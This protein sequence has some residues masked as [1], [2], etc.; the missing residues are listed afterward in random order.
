MFVSGGTTKES[1][2]LFHK[3]EGL[4]EFDFECKFCN[5]LPKDICS[6]FEVV[7]NFRIFNLLL[8]IYNNNAQFLI[9]E[10]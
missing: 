10:N 7:D 4:K 6:E 9:Y 8:K 1:K 2:G 5:M 3:N